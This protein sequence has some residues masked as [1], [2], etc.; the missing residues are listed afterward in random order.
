MTMKT[1]GVNP[2]KDKLHSSLKVIVSRALPDG[3][4]GYADTSSFS[5]EATAWAV[6]ALKACDTQL[7]LAKRAC[8]R[9]VCCQQSDGSICAINGFTAAVWPTSLCLLAWKCLQGYRQPI[10]GGL[11]FLLSFKGQHQRKPAGSPTGHDTSIVGWP[12]VEQTHSWIEP[13][14]LAM[15]ALKANGY[16]DHLRIKEA[17]RML[18]D[19][20]LTGGGW[21]YGNTSVFG[22]EL[23]PIPENTGQALCALSGMT[24]QAYVQRSLSYALRCVRSIR[25]PMALAW[26][27]YGIGMWSQ[28]PQQWERSVIESL[29]LQDRYGPFDT[30]LLSQLLTVYF[31]GARLMKILV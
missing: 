8:D 24:E 3:G 15:L 10:D 29:D 2:D 18:M 19:R 22:K 30:V 26:M 12:W 25:T 21:N 6:M 23:L 5:P 1:Q 4:F 11:R 17:V 20:Q 14:C 27:L 9:L 7:D 16:N 31:T 13:T 28:L